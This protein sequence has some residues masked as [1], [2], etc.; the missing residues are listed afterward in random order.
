MQEESE[1]NLP[2]LFSTGPKPQRNNMTK[3]QLHKFAEILNAKYTEELQW[4]QNLESFRVNMQKWA[5]I[6]TCMANLGINETSESIRGITECDINQSL[7][8]ERVKLQ[9]ASTTKSPFRK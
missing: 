6:H 5:K 2:L 9:P 4:Q 1:S 8:K 7:Q 3:E